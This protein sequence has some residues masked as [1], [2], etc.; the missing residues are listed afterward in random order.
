[1]A[2]FSSQQNWL[3]QRVRRW[4]WK[5]YGRKHGKY[6]FFTNE[7]LHGQYGLAKLPLYSAWSR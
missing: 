3:R 1:V 7:R 4:L 2:A 6:T 5:K